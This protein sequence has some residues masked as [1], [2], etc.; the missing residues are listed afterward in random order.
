MPFTIWAHSGAGTGLP[1][2]AFRASTKPPPNLFTRV[3]VCSSPPTFCR[4][5]VIFPCFDLTSAGEKRQAPTDRSELSSPRKPFTVMAPVV[6][7]RLQVSGPIAALNVGGRAIVPQVNAHLRS[8]LTM[9]FLR[10][11]RGQNE[12]GGDNQQ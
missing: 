11:P 3:K 8:L 4:V 2:A 7:S 5:K 10:E 1:E 6:V 9:V 12:Q